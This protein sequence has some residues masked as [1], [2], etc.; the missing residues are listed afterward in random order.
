VP[1]SSSDD[2]L[3]RRRRQRPP[4][5]TTETDT[6]DGD[7]DGDGV[8]V[9]FALYQDARVMRAATCACGRVHPSC[10]GLAGFAG[11]GALGVPVPVESMPEVDRISE[12]LRALE[13]LQ[14]MLSAE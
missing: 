5:G 2:E 14:A 8:V 9:E 6:G 4:A 10:A 7:G 13:R 12:R 11:P 1:P 3:A